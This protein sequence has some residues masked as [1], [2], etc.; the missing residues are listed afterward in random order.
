MTKGLM[1]TR[2]CWQSVEPTSWGP[3]CQPTLSQ[4]ALEVCNALVVV[5][6]SLVENLWMFL[7]IFC[8]QSLEKLSPGS[9]TSAIGTIVSFVEKGSLALTLPCF[10]AQPQMNHWAPAPQL[11]APLSLLE[12]RAD[13]PLGSCTS[14]NGTIVSFGE[15]GRYEEE[16]KD[17]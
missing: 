8:L 3:S 12:K 5:V 15:K 10:P 16:N 13:E 1:P 6:A 17:C 11:M 7:V 4:A 9:H 14:A 2:N